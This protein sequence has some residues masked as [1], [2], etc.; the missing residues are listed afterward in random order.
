M[1]KNAVSPRKVDIERFAKMAKNGVV[2]EAAVPHLATVYAAMRKAQIAI[3]PGHSPL[4]AVFEA[5]PEDYR[6]NWL[7][8]RVRASAT[9]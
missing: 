5:L 4:D 9:A 2:S 3:G 1:S 6:T 7:A 8:K